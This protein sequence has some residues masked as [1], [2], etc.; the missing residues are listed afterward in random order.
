M[1]INTDGLVKSSYSKEDITFLLKDL[2]DVQIE[3]SVESREQLFQT[4]SHY[5]ETLPIE[6]RPTS[7]DMFL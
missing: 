6:N 3:S 1:T 2:S 7:E 4:G 5:S